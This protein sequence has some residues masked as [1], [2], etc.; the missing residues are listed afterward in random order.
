MSMKRLV[1][2]ALVAATLAFPALAQCGDEGG[3]VLITGANRG[4]GLA[5]AETFAANGFDVVG[6]ARS[7]EKATELKAL[8]VRVEQLDVTAVLDLDGSISIPYQADEGIPHLTIIG[9]DGTVQV[10]H[11][12]VYPDVSVTERKLRG[13]LES[14]IAGENLVQTEQAN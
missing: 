12:G 5:L 9:R 13:D 7:P 14:L 10:V 3:T 2:A 8:G 1:S 11:I 6:T 4:I